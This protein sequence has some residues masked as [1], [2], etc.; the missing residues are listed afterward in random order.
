MFGSEDKS[1]EGAGGKIKS[2][3]LEVESLIDT[4]KKLSE[5]GLTLS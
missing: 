2:E 4:I 5:V 1:L 3:C